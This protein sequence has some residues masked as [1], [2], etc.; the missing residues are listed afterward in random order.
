MVL[1]LIVYDIS[2]LFNIRCSHGNFAVGKVPN[3]YQKVN[4]A[5]LASPILIYWDLLLLL[6]LLLLL[7]LL[8]LLI[9]L[10]LLQ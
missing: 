10:L 8:I 1:G 4:F 6:L 9:L 3:S 2:H 7:I 5:M